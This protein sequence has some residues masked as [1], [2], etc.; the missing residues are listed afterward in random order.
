MKEGTW[1]RQLYSKPLPEVSFILETEKLNKSSKNGQYK[2]EP[3][4]DTIEESI[5]VRW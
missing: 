3:S 2:K 4:Y 1:P 5:I